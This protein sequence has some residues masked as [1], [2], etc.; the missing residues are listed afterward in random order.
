MNV[1]NNSWDEFVKYNFLEDA[2]SRDEDDEEKYGK[3]LDLRTGEVIKLDAGEDYAPMPADIDACEAM[4]EKICVVCPV[5]GDYEPD[6]VF[7][8]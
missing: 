5:S 3:P 1:F 7:L 6:G 4:M 8:I 2:I